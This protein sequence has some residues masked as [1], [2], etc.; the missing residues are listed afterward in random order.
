MTPPARRD[1]SW[2][3]L[4]VGV[5][6][7]LGVAM[8]ILAVLSAGTSPGGSEQAAPLRFIPV[9]AEAGS[10]CSVEEPGRTV[11]DDG[12][13]LTLRDADGMAVQRVQ[14]AHAEPSPAGDWSVLIVLRSTDARA[15]GDLTATV[16]DEGRGGSRLA[17]LLG[18]RL[19]TAPVV[20]SRID[21]G[22]VVVSGFSREEAED[23]AGRLRA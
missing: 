12:V 16:A 4:L 1:G 23:L 2:P 14:D 18:E 3:A 20:T 22:E 13:C 8:T 17:M 7:L 19:L 15:F 5:L 9:A 11:T 10:P 6:A 21:G